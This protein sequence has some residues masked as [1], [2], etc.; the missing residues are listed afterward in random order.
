[1]SLTKYRDPVTGEWKPVAMGVG[2]TF[3]PSVSEDGTLSWSNDR[4]LP[5]PAPVV[6]KGTDGTDGD[7]GVS[8]TH[9][10]NGTVLSVT[11][12]SGTSSA[13]LKGSKGDKG[14]A[15]T[16]NDTD[17]NTIAAAVKAS[18]PT[19]SWTFELEDGSTVTKAVYIG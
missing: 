15:Y 16:L 17:K 19:E 11:S 14:D 8:C 7:D 9:S 4:D 13:D 18:L 3:T 12:A 2:A 1:M 6:I 10:W 5:N